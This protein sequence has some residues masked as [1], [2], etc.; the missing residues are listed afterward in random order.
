MIIFIGAC[1]P[2]YGLQALVYNIEKSKW[3]VKSALQ[4]GRLFTLDLLFAFC[5]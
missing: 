3:H 1:E 5:Y 2:D 4:K